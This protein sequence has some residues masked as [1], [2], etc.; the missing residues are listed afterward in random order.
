M[1]VT[2]PILIQ[3]RLS[4]LTEATCNKVGAILGYIPFMHYAIAL[5][6]YLSMHSVAD[7]CRKE[8]E[9]SK[10]TNAQRE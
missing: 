5:C 9:G 8:E 3:L 2:A 1:Q 7:P 10:Q 4:L 6:R